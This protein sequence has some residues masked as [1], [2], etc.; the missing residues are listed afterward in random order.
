MSST[1]IHTFTLR[2]RDGTS[3]EYILRE[4]PTDPGLEVVDRLLQLGLGPILQMLVETVNLPDNFSDMSPEVKAELFDGIKKKVDVGQIAKQVLEGLTRS[5]GLRAIAPMLLAYCDRN[6][7][8]LKDKMNFAAA[9]QA[10]YAEL[11][12]ACQKSI[13]HNGFFDLLTISIE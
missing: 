12:G 1:P 11:I 13:S 4:H 7:Q 2:D 5:G 6:G 10:N 3:H 8:P 9:Y